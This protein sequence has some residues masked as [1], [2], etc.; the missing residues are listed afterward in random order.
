MTGAER[1]SRDRP[2]A[3]PA[4]HGRPGLPDADAG[5]LDPIGDSLPDLGADRVMAADCNE[6]IVISQLQSARIAE[7]LPVAFCIA[8]SVMHV[9]IIQ[10]WRASPAGFVNGDFLWPRTGLPHRACEHVTRRL[11]EP[12]AP[13]PLVISVSVPGAGGL[14]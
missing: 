4:D 12:P 2:A 1:G 6:Q 9:Q 8:R 7:Y 10:L 13:D 3:G 11:K 14:C 5:P